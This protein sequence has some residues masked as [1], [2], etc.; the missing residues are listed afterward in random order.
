MPIAIAI[1]ISSLNLGMVSNLTWAW[2]IFLEIMNHSVNVMIYSCGSEQFRKHLKRLICRN[3]M[4]RDEN[5][6]SIIR[7]THS[8]N[9][10]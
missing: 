2:M 6:H 4:E 10:K 5:Q 8:T 7:E 9:F 3:C 1:V